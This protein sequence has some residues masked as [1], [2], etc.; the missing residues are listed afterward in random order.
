MLKLNSAKAEH[1][2]FGGTAVLTHHSAYILLF[3]VNM[4]VYQKH[5]LLFQMMHTIIK[6]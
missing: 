4:Y 2:N 6:S 1:I 3:S 5:F